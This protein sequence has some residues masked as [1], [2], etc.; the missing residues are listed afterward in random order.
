MYKYNVYVGMFDKD[1]KKQVLSN[2]EFLNT[3]RKIMREHKNTDFT[4]YK[5]KG[6]Y[7]HIDGKTVCEPS[8]NIEIIDT[9]N[10]TNE[11]YINSIKRELCKELNQESVLITKQEIQVL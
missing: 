10:W 11:L 3:V 8:L 2:T 5:C 9:N 6:H 7:Q 4:I 1:T